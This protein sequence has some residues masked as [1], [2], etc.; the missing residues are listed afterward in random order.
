MT[1]L[2]GNQTKEQ[3]GM[4][5]R[6]SAQELECKSHVELGDVDSALRC[7][8][9][10]LRMRKVP[11]RA[12]CAGLLELCAMKAPRRASYVLEGM[13][14]QRKLEL[15]AYCRIVR[16]F[17]MNRV[18]TRAIEDFDE[19]AVDT[20]SFSDDGPHNYFA[21][22]ATLLNLELNEAVAQGGAGG[23]QVREEECEV[24]LLT[25]KRQ[26]GAAAMLCTRG[27]TPL[28]AILLSG[29]G[30]REGA[31]DAAEVRQLAESNQGLAAPEL[32]AQAR[33]QIESLE[34]LNESQKAAASACV[35]RRLTLVQ[36]PPGTGKTTVAVQVITT[37]VRALGLRPVLPFPEPSLNLP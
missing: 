2:T 9:R 16:L 17:L 19:L 14:E 7:F 20:L 11:H 6:V 25:H 35:D 29:F 37:W 3:P 27:G 1:R 23:G 26:L 31:Q 28:L 10:S 22:L 24:S 8:E 13:G 34:T 18:D 30:G 33:A 5:D 12:I 36:G 21:H 32:A 4:L 15:D